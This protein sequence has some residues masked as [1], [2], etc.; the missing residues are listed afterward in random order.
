MTSS[1]YK[2]DDTIHV[3]ESVSEINITN[4]GSG[5]RTPIVTIADPPSGN[6]ATA[7]AIST[8]TIASI[9]VDDHGK[10]YKSDPT[11]QITGTG[12][13]ATAFATFGVV[14]G[15][16]NILGGSGYT[17]NFQVIFEPIS[18]GSGAAGIANVVNGQVVS[19]SI[20]DG[21]S[22]YAEGPSVDFSKGSG[23]NAQGIATGIFGGV[24]SVTVTNGGSNY[25]NDSVKVIFSGGRGSGAKASAKVSGVVSSIDLVN[26]GSGYKTNPNVT[27]TDSDDGTGTGATATATVDEIDK[28]ENILVDDISITS[29]MVSPGGGGIL[30]LYFSM[31][32]DDGM[33]SETNSTISVFNNNVKKGELN[34]DNSSKVETNG[35]YRFDL[36]VKSGD[37]INFQSSEDID[38]IHFIRTHLIQFGA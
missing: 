26:G 9:V 18:G 24:F 8:G 32:F 22:G 28:N 25:D 36:D 21:G 17:S 3:N 1:I 19:V 20:S 33:G 4:P 16:D 35:Y 5:Y 37:M 31:A 34:A 10:D 13:G 30:R 15:V 23:K 14:E 38:E 7:T 11:V 27:I 6:T 29:E 2:I 12:T